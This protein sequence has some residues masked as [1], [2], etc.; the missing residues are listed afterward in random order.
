MRLR[1]VSLLLL[2]LGGAGAAA[3]QEPKAIL[4]VWRGTSLCVNREAAPACRDEQ[5]IYEFK[6]TSPPS[7]GKLTLS[8]DKI[9]EGKPVLMGVF[10]LAWDPKEGAWTSEIQNSRLHI[11]WSFASRGDDLTG[12]LVLLPGRTLVRKAAARR[13]P[14]T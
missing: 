14:K 1:D 12:T 5:V 7:A 2:I 6:E 9:E 11:L 13:A 4:G 10:D 3:A 8:A